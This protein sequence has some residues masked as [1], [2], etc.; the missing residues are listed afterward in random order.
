L[1]LSCV[2]VIDVAAEQTANSIKATT[3][4]LSLSS[5]SFIASNRFLSLPPPEKKEKLLK[6]SKRKKF[7]QFDTQGE[8]ERERQYGIKKKQ[9]EKR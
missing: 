4:F 3:L 9:E 6:I 8:R 2:V 7:R 1:A 5:F